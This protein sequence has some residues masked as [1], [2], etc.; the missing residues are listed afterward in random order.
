MY[1]CCNI[2]HAGGTK[3]F[4]VKLLAEGPDCRPASWCPVCGCWCRTMWIAIPIHSWF[5]PFVPICFKL[6]DLIDW[7]SR[8]R[9]R[10]NMWKLSCQ[11]PTS[12]ERRRRKWP[13]R[14]C[15]SWR[16]WTPS[17]R[18]KLQSPRRMQSPGGPGGFW[19]F[20]Q[21]FGASV[22]F[23]TWYWSNLVNIQIFSVCCQVNVSHMS[24]KNWF[25]LGQEW[26]TCSTQC[27]QRLGAHHSAS[28]RGNRT[29]TTATAAGRGDG[30]VDWMDSA[31][32][33][34]CGA[35]GAATGEHRAEP[36]ELFDFTW[37]YPALL[38]YKSTKTATSSDLW[39]CTCLKNSS[40]TKDIKNKK[41]TR[42]GVDTG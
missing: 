4:Q 22:D 33:C 28:Q 36:A 8:W 40:T 6:Q 29:A 20:C 39:Y 37:L 30:W 21:S 38:F 31:D 24:R 14:S 5:L 26:G 11:Q 23:E 1:R 7:W 10:W 42:Q 27:L 34:N 41:L 17:S 12:T 2:C 18:R 32:G 13:N 25:I 9:W 19:E 3:A 16:R 35:R 15:R